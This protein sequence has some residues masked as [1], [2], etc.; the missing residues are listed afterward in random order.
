MAKITGMRSFIKEAKYATIMALA[1]KSLIVAA[2]AISFYAGSDFNNVPNL[3]N[4]WYTGPDDLSSW[5]IPFSNWDGQY[6]LLLSD[7]GY[8]YDNTPAS[9]R[10]FFPLY[11]L[12][13]RTLSYVMPR[14]V[15]ATLLSYLLTAG[16]CFFLLKLGAH[17]G[18]RKCHLVVL[19]T[20]SFPTAFFASVFYTEA[21]FL[22]LQIGFV[23]H[24]LVTRSRKAWIYAAL[25]PLTRGTA[26]F[27]FVGVFSYVLLAYFKYQQDANEKRKAQARSPGRR[28]KR[29]VKDTD[30]VAPARSD[31]FSWSYYCSCAYAFIVGGVLYLAFFGVTTGDP[32]AGI[33]AQDTFGLNS[34]SNLLDPRHF[35]A[36]LFSDSTSWF[37]ARDSLFNKTFVIAA[38]LC[39]LIFVVYREWG[40]LCF[41]LPLIYGQA[42][43]GVG[44]SFPR[45]CLVASPFLAL[46]I[47]KNIKQSWLVYVI[48]AAMFALQLY[49]LNNFSLNFW[50]A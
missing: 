3:W 20:L 28:R 23:Y 5:Y 49:L 45:F 9:P 6:Y 4:R 8:N 40:L 50:I 39:C 36:Y 21:L 10:A 44:V 38:M 15:A 24:F 48:C 12:L 1:A 33:A 34:I 35:V 29:I 19:L 46:A 17:F 32:L 41:F 7:W 26:L 25:L 37:G 13:I 47:A 18:C 30:A 16:L 22:F 31:T 27:F 11:P 43:M 2:L 14:M 42:A